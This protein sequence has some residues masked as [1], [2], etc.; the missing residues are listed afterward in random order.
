MGT[1]QG[2]ADSARTVTAGAIGNGLEW[3]DFGLFG[4]FAPIFSSQFF[5]SADPRAALL[6]TSESSRSP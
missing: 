3:Y 4:Y 2:R 5:P 1:A 6:N